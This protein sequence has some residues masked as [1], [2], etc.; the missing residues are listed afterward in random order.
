MP[1]S[2]RDESNV[3]QD[4]VFA[5]DAGGDKEADQSLQSLTIVAADPARSASPDTRRRPRRGAP[6]PGQ[7]GPRKERYV[8]RRS[9]ALG[10]GSATPLESMRSSFG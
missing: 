9:G 2:S 1:A 3:H 8:M 7:P 5:E 6:L 4:Q 10:P